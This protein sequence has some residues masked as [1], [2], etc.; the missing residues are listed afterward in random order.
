MRLIT[1]SRDGRQKLGAWIDDDQRIVDLHAAALLA[2]SRHVNALTSMLS[3]IEAGQSALDDV[4]G[5]VKEP[6]AEVVVATDEVRLLAPL[7]VPAQ[8]RDFMSFEQHLINAWL[9]QAEIVIAGADDPEMKRQELAEQGYAGVPPIWYEQAI[10]YTTNRFQVSAPGDEIQWPTYSALMDFE[11]EFAAIIGKSGKDIEA[12][13]AT[14]Y[15]FGYTIYNDWSARDM[16]A[17]VMEGRLGPGRGKEFDGGITLG[18]CIVTA[19]E[20]GDPYSLSMRAFVNGVQWAE[21][22]TSTMYRRFE[23]CIRDLTESQTIHPG[24]VLGSGT[25]A[26]GC[27]LEQN[28]FLQDGDLV[29]LEVERIGRISNRVQMSERQKARLSQ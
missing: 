14:E 16:Q 2:G 21:G 27:G 9:A 1:Y 8:I 13:Q 5:L 19:D 12:R 15:I 23:D 20:I 7:P 28:R 29:E 24:E 3:L 17:K 10:Y 11:L 25:V 6:P 22:S 18:P 26:T 4:R